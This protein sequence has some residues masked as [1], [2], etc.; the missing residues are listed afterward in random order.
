MNISKHD[1][2]TSYVEVIEMAHI[3][4]QD[5]VDS[6]GFVG[7]AAHYSSCISKAQI[8]L[9]FAKSYAEAYGV[10]MDGVE[11]WR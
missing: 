7:A 9:A 6:I 3:I 5:G 8:L 4:L 2:L 11:P 1:A 10:N